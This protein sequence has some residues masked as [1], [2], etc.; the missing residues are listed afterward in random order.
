MIDIHF[1]SYSLLY[2]YS[3]LWTFAQLF[4][5][6][7]NWPNFDMVTSKHLLS[8]RLG[9]KL[10]RLLT[11]LNETYSISYWF[12]KLVTFAHLMFNL[13]FLLVNHTIQDLVLETIGVTNKNSLTYKVIRYSPFTRVSTLRAG[14]DR[15]TFRN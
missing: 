1:E 5:P 11:R 12:P 6:Y 15:C 13:V 2:G 8:S 3:Y 7:Y 14:A 4:G 9:R 10:C